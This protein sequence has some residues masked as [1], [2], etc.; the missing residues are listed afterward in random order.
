MKYFGTDGIRGKAY[1]FINFDL[2]FAVGRSMQLFD[3]DKIVISRDTR[4]SGLM[5]VNAIKQGAMAS[6]I[7]VI[8]IDILAT[9]ILSY[10][11]KI[12]DCIGI[13]VTA[14]H[15]PYV[16]NGIKLF[17]RGHKLLTEQEEKIEN[18]ID[19]VIKLENPKKVGVELSETNPLSNYLKLFKPFLTKTHLNIVLDFANGATI[20][21]GKF[22]FN[23]I[24]SKTL[25][26][27][28]EPNGR[29]INK[30]CGSTHLN[31]LVD[32]M[33]SSK[34][35]I[36][37][38]F[39]GDGDRFLVV[40][41]NG[42]IIDGDLLIYIF[43]IYLKEKNQ[44]KN[45]IVVLTK[46]SNLGIIKALENKGIKVI[47]TDIGDKHVFAG[48]DKYDAV[49]GG[50][51]SGHV[52]NRVLFDTGDGV[53]NA[54]YVVKILT[55]KNCDILDLVKDIEMYP[56]RLINLRN[57]DRD[58]VNHP[59]ITKLVENIKKDLNGFGKIL[60]RASGTEPLI[61]VSASAQTE[62]KV[63]QILQTVIDK[64]NEI[65]YQNEQKK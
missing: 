46:M 56:D 44:L 1:D 23:Q 54:A 60:V 39:D 19:E 57:I 37:F 41:K 50:E 58:L 21:S 10:M 47:Q 64:L 22:I 24:T 4:E 32:H 15:N 26:I 25:F 2:A 51:N 9:P 40:S 38:A 14:S 45:D 34:S 36:G 6:G 18:V 20:K 28:D 30:D 49:I 27:G 7:D 65:Q 63:D 43:A 35:D 3:T 12:H 42:T 48:L 52:I 31:Y 11:S 62:K 59:E 17:D 8:D 5:I 29:N 16:D 33:K 53:L 61:R 13:M 55:E